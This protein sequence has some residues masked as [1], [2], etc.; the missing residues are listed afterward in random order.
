[1]K[2]I[3]DN[4]Y[5]EIILYLSIWWL[6]S[7]VLL[8]DTNLSDTKLIFCWKKAYGIQSPLRKNKVYNF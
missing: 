7:V 3:K 6:T 2:S 8:Q 1:M 5:F 4:A